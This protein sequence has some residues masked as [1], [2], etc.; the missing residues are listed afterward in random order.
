MKLDIDILTESIKSVK[1]FRQRKKERE[2]TVKKIIC[3]ILLVSML[4]LCF[5]SCESEEPTVDTN[6]PAPSMENVNLTSTSSIENVKKT[7]K[8]TNYVLI[9]V[10][11][12][13]K[14]LV[15]LFPNVAPQTVENFK[16]L[17]SEKFYDGIIFHRVIKDFMIQ[18]GDPDGTGMGGSEKTIPGEFK[19]NGFTNNLLHVRGVLSMARTNDPNSASSQFFIMHEAAKHLDGNYAAF[20]YVVYG[21]DVVDDIAET[22]VDDGDKPI[23]DIVIRSIRFADV[24][25]VNFDIKFDAQ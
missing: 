1:I 17:V 16:N 12:Y 20:G 7:D 8:P 5:V 9:D 3:A 10:S 14:I 22:R 21:M 13:G 2:K 24:S 19:S 4:M 11:G 15:R 18:G 25:N 6:H 23:K